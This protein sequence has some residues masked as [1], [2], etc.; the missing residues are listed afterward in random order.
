MAY[1]V[2][3]CDINWGH[4]MTS[5]HCMTSFNKFL[6]ER[7]V[8]C[9]TQKMCEIPHRIIILSPSSMVGWFL[10]WWIYDKPFWWRW[11]VVKKK[12][13]AE[14][15]YVHLMNIF[16]FTVGRFTVVLLSTPLCRHCRDNHDFSTVDTPFLL[17]RQFYK[18]RSPLMGQITA[19]IITYKSDLTTV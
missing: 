14:N 1:G 19:I 3:S 15:G 16:F 10:V 5:W 9:L 18:P 7:T 8:E 6:G 12:K 17:C 13:T 2:T 11:S 4:G